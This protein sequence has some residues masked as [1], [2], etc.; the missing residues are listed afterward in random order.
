MFMQ[1]T[2][3]ILFV[4]DGGGTLNTVIQE[5]SGQTTVDP[6]TRDSFRKE[7]IQI[8]ESGAVAFG[9]LA[10]LHLALG[11]THPFEETLPNHPLFLELSDIAAEYQLPI[12]LHLEAVTTSTTT[13]TTLYKAALENPATLQSNIV[14]FE[15]LLNHNKNATIVWLQAGWDHT[16]DKTI[17]LM[18][19]L[20][21]DHPNLYLGLKAGTDS[22]TDTGPFT[23]E[24][25]VKQEWITFLT[26]Y[27]DR[28]VIAS[29]N[30]FTSDTLEQTKEPSQRQ[31]AIIKILSALP[32]NVA[33]QIG[34]EN[35]NKLFSLE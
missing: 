7:A 26:T 2:N 31:D 3:D 17:A 6:I 24:G 10:A 11:P 20:L 29:D 23:D 14:A 4:S 16:G 18:S 19:T 33:Q 27:A 9:E 15:E 25:E 8:A 22:R 34:T 28:C 30:F 12:L 5:T 32:S 35:A 1:Y 13:P 21:D